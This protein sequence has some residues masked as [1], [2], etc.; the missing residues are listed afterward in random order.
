M[1]RKNNTLLTIDLRNNP[2]YDENIH[3]RL[4][5]KMSKNIHFLY[6]QYQS[7]AYTDEEF[8]GFLY[9]DRD[10]VYLRRISDAR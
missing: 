3:S 10:V 1:M 7:G 6:Q 9:R 2:G 8:D 4:V 5:M